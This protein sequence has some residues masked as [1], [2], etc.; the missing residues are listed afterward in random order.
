MWF[1]HIYSYIYLFI[2]IYFNVVQVVT[3]IFPPPW[4]PAPCI[5]TSYPQTYPI[6][7]CP[8]V[9]YTCSLVDLPLFC[10]IITLPHPSGYCQF[11]LYFNLS[12]Y[13]LLACLFVLLIRLNLKV[14]SY[15]IS[16]SPPDLFHLK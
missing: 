1:S 10:P 16:L 13:I 3:S 9:F 6:W 11:V 14:R 15:G 8:C 7:L 2:D 12:G 5:P 4:S